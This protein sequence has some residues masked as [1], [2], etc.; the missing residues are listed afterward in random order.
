MTVPEARG[1]RQGCGSSG[2]L[3]PVEPVGIVELPASRAME[4]G[5]DVTG[6]KGLQFRRAPDFCAVEFTSGS[7]RGLSFHKFEP[8]TDAPKS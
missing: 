7:N 5:V 6:K 2:F 3:T 4:Q 8:G 1:E